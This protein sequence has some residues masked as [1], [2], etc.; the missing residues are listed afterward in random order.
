MRDIG[1][2]DISTTEEEAI[3]RNKSSIDRSVRLLRNV[4]P[5]LQRVSAEEIGSTVAAVI[6]ILYRR[7]LIAYCDPEAT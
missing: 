7:G 2:L 1:S 4:T 3:R 5:E 6:G